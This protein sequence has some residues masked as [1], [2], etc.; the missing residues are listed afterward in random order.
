M[1][2]YRIT[3]V[4]FLL[5]LPLISPASLAAKPHAMHQ[6]SLSID[7]KGKQ[8]PAAEHPAPKKHTFSKHGSKHIKKHTPHHLAKHTLTSAKHTQHVKK[9]S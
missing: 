2:I 5:A 4:A 1:I 7:Q 9:L 6:S 8:A 3:I